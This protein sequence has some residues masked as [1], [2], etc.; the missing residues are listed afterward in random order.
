MKSPSSQSSGVALI[1]A[2]L[3]VALAT[4]LATALISQLFMDTR[5]TEN[6]LSNEQAY[7]Y[8][9][10]AEKIA[11]NLLFEDQQNSAYDSLDE[12][13]AAQAPPF[14]VEGGQVMVSMEDLQGRFN[15]NNLSK[16]INNAGQQ[17][18]VQVF[19]R[20]LTQ[21]QIPPTLS[22]AVVDWL[23]A[24]LET[25]IPNGAEDDYYMSLTTPYRAA[26]TLISSPSELRL[27]KGFN[28]KVSETETAYQR[29]I[30]FVSALPI[31]TDI[32]VNTA[33]AE[34]LISASADIEA[35][36]AAKIIQYRGVSIVEPGTPYKTL[37]EFKNYMQDTLNKENFDT[38]GLNI[39]TQYF[40]LQSYAQ[41]GQGH[42]RLYSILNRQDDGRITTISRSQEVW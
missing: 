7:L 34:V 25:T 30:K 20:L 11:T 8:A 27:I 24:D 12:I 22:D 6:I 9:L 33:P 4:V 3:V 16:V 40:L 18:A 14:P 29:I 13:W 1:T 2:M 21:L 35:A 37:D 5:R 10:S 31:V 28:D 38:A 26:N 41:I 15:L 23:D 42:S 39:K 17:N 19:K 36:D 32:N